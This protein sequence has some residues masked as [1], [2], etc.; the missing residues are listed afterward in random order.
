M[1]SFD[2]PLDDERTQ[3][4]AFVEEYRS[5]LE[6]TLDG[7]TEDLV[8]PEATAGSDPSWFGFPIGVRENAPFRREDL[9]RALETNKIGTR[10]LFGGNLLRQPAYQDCDYRVVGELR[11]TDFVMNNVFWVG[12]FPGLT[13]QMLDFVAKTIQNFVGEAKSYSG[14]KLPAAVQLG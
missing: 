12:V 4:E 5:A 7:L 3:L 6:A 14:K 2:V 9:T 13:A 10:L 1:G 11:N 8:L